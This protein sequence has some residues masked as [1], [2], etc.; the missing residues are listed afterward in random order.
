MANESN[1]SVQKESQR[2]FEPSDAFVEKARIRSR[3][4][5]DRLYRESLD[6]PD[7]FWKRET[8][9]LVFRTPWTKTHEWK[10]P[11]AKWFLGATLNAT[12]SC[13]DRHLGTWRRNKAAILW[14]GELGATRTLTYDQLHR[15]TVRFA[16]AL[17]ANGIQKGDRVAIYMGMV[18]E[19][20]I[21]M[22]AC[23]RL[24]AIHTV[25]FGGFAA[26]AIASRV[27]D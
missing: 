24:G 21:A 10:L 19:V 12:E 4:E 27:S 7:T 17:A 18:P 2:R 9:D 15:E 13:L 20:A 16:N 1:T 8:Q 11:D 6:D 25:I 23:A 14:E 5:Y 26:D 22:L 3:A